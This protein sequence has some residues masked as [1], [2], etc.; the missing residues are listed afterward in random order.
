MRRKLRDACSKR[1]K[2][3]AIYDKSRRPC[4]RSIRPKPVS[5]AGSS[6][7]ARTDGPLDSSAPLQINVAVFQSPVALGLSSCDAIIGSGKKAPSHEDCCQ[8]LGVPHGHRSR[9][10][11]RRTAALHQRISVGIR[12]RWILSSHRTRPEPYRRIPLHL[13]KW[14][15][16]E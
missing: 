7:Y 4:C 10:G 16:D 3:P 5:R 13:R 6:R 15:P 9:L 12:S 11:E 1:R 14:R 2:F 8:L